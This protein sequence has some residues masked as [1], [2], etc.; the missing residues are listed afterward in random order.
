MNTRIK[1]I[2]VAI[3][4]VKSRAKIAKDNGDFTQFRTL[5]MDL[6]SLENC[7]VTECELLSNEEVA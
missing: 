4:S 2:L 7:L 1:D 6:L 5:M 3:R